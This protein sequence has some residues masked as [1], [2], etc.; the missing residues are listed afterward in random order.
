MSSNLA[1]SVALL[2][3][4]A[5][6]NAYEVKAVWWTLQYGGNFL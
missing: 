3:S 2:S 4:G 5:L 6:V 1:R